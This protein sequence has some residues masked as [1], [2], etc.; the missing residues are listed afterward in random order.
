MLKT[1]NIRNTMFEAFARWR[2]RQRLTELRDQLSRQALPELKDFW[3]YASVS[4]LRYLAEV[5]GM[6]LAVPVPRAQIE[7]WEVELEAGQAAANATHPIHQLPNAETI[8]RTLHLYLSALAP[9]RDPDASA[10]YWTPL[11]CFPSLDEM[12][13]ELGQY[14]TL[15][16]CDIPDDPEGK[17]TNL[18]LVVD[19]YKHCEGLTGDLR[20][21]HFE[22]L[23]LQGAEVI[24]KIDGALVS[25]KAALT[26]SG[27][28]WDMDGVSSDLSTAARM[29]CESL[30]PQEV[31][32]W[33]MAQDLFS[34]PAG[35]PRSTVHL[36]SYETNVSNVPGLALL[37]AI[38]H[39]VDSVGSEEQWN[40]DSYFQAKAVPNETGPLLDLTDQMRSERKSLEQPHRWGQ[41]SLVTVQSPL[42]SPFLNHAGSTSALHQEENAEARALELVMCSALA[43]KYFQA[44]RYPP[45]YWYYNPQNVGCAPDIPLAELARS[46]TSGPYTLH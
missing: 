34:S 17:L 39:L 8:A 46:G 28:Y 30:L 7:Q 37:N 26:D 5:H 3:R 40:L 10:Q 35:E 19:L 16:N 13:D 25:S 4:P 29:I 2:V 42:A 38:I 15:Y 18:S 36:F 32:A 9:V 43:T 22:C 31:N 41:I 20:V 44:D 45:F 21:W 12:L 14:V 24:A 1:Y 11:S 6:K 27:Y 33:R 23:L